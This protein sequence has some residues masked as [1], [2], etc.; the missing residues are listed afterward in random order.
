MG[1]RYST[2]STE[3]WRPKWG[4]NKQSSAGGGVFFS[5]H[6]EDFAWA[7]SHL[8]EDWKP[9]ILLLYFIQNTG[10]EF[11]FFF[12]FLMCPRSH[13]NPGLYCLQLLGF[14]EQKSFPSEGNSGSD[15]NTRR[16]ALR[17]AFCVLPWAFPLFPSFPQLRVMRHHLKSSDG[18]LILLL[19]CI[20]WWLRQ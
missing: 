10:P 9:L 15:W 12:F 17:E 14:S 3:S 6:P 18:M 20:P 2:G 4:T 16:E 13:N 7:V 5:Q 19:S 1:T 8:R 11:S